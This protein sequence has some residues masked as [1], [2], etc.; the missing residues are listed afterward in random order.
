MLRAFKNGAIQDPVARRIEQKR[1]QRLNRIKSTVKARGH[2]NARRAAM[3]RLNRRGLGG[4]GGAGGA[5]PAS[6]PAQWA[7]EPSLHK[8]SLLNRRHLRDVTNRARQSALEKEEEEEEEEF[9]GGG[10]AYADENERRPRDPNSAEAILARAKM[11]LW[12][13]FLPR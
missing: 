5:L 3:Q 6:L 1:L 4:A 9:G 8:R 13:A 11:S 10:G 7:S 2:N 12:T